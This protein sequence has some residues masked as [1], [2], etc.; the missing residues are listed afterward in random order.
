MSATTGI[1]GLGTSLL[2]KSG[3]MSTSRCR[4]GSARVGASA[5]DERITDGLRS[6]ADR[7][8]SIHLRLIPALLAEDKGLGV[9]TTGALV[10]SAQAVGKV[11]G[12]PECE[13]L[14]CPGIQ[15][16]S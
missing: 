11:R 5:K 4:R 15:G 1:Q 3:L 9:L 12:V 13:E 16:V 10:K 6:G 14:R 8:Q 2:M 7:T